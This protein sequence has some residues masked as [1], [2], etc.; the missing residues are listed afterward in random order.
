VYDSDA[1]HFSPVGKTER[2]SQ[3]AKDIYT[4]STMEFPGEVL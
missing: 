2:R 3:Q 4:E 1:G